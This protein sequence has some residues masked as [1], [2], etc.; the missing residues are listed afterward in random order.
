M[1]QESEVNDSKNHENSQ[2][3]KQRSLSSRFKVSPTHL[4]DNENP[5]TKAFKAK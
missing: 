3:K 1:K 4:Q 5:M 2:D